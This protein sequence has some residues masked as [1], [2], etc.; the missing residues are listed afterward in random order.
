MIKNY[1]ELV[2]PGIIYGNALVAATGFV[3]ASGGYVDWKLFFAML[4]GLSM[5]IGSACAFNN[6]YDR[7]MDARMD[8]TKRRPTVTGQISS[9]N[10]LVFAFGLGLLGA[11]VLGFFTTPLTLMWAFIGFFVYV[12]LYT[13]LKQKTPWALFVGAVAGATP[14]VVGY[15]AVTSMFDSAAWGLFI[16]M[17]LWQIPHFLAIAT[18]RYSEYTAAGVP[19]FIRRESS[20]KTKRRARGVFYA[21]LVVLLVACVVLMLQR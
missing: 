1:Y 20:A 21:S 12:V 15:I 4:L 17:F 7:K 10:A 5:V 9:I 18:Y 8:R 3:F 11:V 19:L 16:A 6:V 14:P 2:K 13:P